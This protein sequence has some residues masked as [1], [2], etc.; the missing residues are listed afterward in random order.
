MTA[1]GNV[2]LPLEIAGDTEAEEKAQAMLDRVGL[3]HRASH[4]PT[5]LSGG[6]QQRVG[7]ARAVVNK[8]PLLLADEPTGN[9]DQK[10]SESIFDLLKSITNTK[11]KSVIIT[12]HNPLLYKNSHRA[13][14]MI[15]GR[16]RL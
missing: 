6:E 12:T 2:T 9:L 1:L 10:N 8:P 7:I 13:I 16:L 3:S 14:E 4:Y 11:K 15:N 5:Q